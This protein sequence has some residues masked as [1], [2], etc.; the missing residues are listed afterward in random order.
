MCNQTA[1]LKIGGEVLVLPRR[2]L[3]EEWTYGKVGGYACPYGSTCQPRKA[4]Y[5]QKVIV[6]GK[7]V[8]QNARL[9]KDL[10]MG[11]EHRGGDDW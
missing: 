11:V 10:S 9:I 2:A 1:E 7:M 4:S 5:P 6:H 3:R 8:I